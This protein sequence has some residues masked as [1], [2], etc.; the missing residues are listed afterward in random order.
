LS[1]LW[2][3]SVSVSS[4]TASLRNNWRSLSARLMLVIVILLQSNVSQCG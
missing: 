1:W 3:A 2:V 4:A